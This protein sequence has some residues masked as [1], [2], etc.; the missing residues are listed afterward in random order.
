MLEG[1]GMGFALDIKNISGKYVKE[2]IDCS[3]Q[4][5]DVRFRGNLKEV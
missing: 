2:G 4:S 1:A 5:G 3:M